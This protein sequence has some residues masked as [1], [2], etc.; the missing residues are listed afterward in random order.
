MTRENVFEKVN[1]LCKDVF[2]D[3]E[4]VINEKMTAADV[5]GWDSLT[6]VQL[7]SEI[8]GAFNI[9]FT[10]GE[11]QKFANIGELIDTIMNKLDK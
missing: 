10:L 11:I 5:E 2:D 3:E 6:H 1:E 7:I 9:K 4:L 8:E